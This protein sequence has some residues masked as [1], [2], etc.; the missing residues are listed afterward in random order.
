MAVGSEAS[1][2]LAWRCVRSP[3]DKWH[4]AL[5]PVILMNAPRGRY[6]RFIHPP[7]DGAPTFTMWDQ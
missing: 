1:S 7:L 2:W 4:K 6:A 3:I 5:A